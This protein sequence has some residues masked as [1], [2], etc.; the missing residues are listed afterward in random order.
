MNWP[1]KSLQKFN[2]FL[3]DCKWQCKSLLKFIPSFFNKLRFLKLLLNSFNSLPFSIK[4]CTSGSRF[5]FLGPLPF[6]ESDAWNVPAISLS[7]QPATDGS[8]TVTIILRSK[9]S[10]TV[11]GPGASCVLLLAEDLY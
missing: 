11:V 10:S 1:V 5:T 7:L 6:L 9:L 2:S 8:F 3:L 4:V